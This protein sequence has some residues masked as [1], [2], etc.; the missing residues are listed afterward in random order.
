MLTL[1]KNNS[2]YTIKIELYTINYNLKRERGRYL[3]FVCK[4]SEGAI[5]PLKLRLCT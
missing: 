2:N 3:C 4:I 1:R 5:V